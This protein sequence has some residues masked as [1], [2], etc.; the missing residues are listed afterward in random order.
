M[1]TVVLRWGHSE[2][3][4]CS[5]VEG[6]EPGDHLELQ[7]AAKIGIKH[8]LTHVITVTSILSASFLNK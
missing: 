5:S 3:H 1:R 7:E 6:L 4:C 2:I 8:C